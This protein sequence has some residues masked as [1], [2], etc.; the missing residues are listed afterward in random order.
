[1]LTSKSSDVSLREAL[2]WKNCRFIVKRESLQ[3]AKALIVWID[4]I[5][6]RDGA[7]Y[8]SHDESSKIRSDVLEED[9]I[10]RLKFNDCSPLNNAKAAIYLSK[11]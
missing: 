7:E 2:I 5:F 8:F 4:I 6:L 1:M 3:R 10:T 11:G 9:L